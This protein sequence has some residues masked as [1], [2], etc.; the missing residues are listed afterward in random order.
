MIG[1]LVR[2][3]GFRKYTRNRVAV[4]A[5]GVVGVYALVAIWVA[6]GGVS[7]N[8]VNRRVLPNQWPGAF[9]ET[10]SFEKQVKEMRDRANEI[11]RVFGR[12]AASENPLSNLQ[13]LN[14]AERD[15]LEAPF[16]ELQLLAQRVFEARDELIQPLSRY[17]DGADLVAVAEEEI[18]KL[19]EQGVTSGPAYDRFKGGLEEG[20]ADVENFEPLVAEGL[21]KLQASIDALIPE[22][23]GWDGFIYSLRTVLGSDSQGRSISSKAVYSTKVA[24]QIGFVVAMFC[25][26]FGTLMG[27]AA[28][29]YGGWVDYFVMWLVSTL[30]SIPYIVLLAVIVFMFTGHDLFDNASKPGFALVPVYAAMGLTF[31]ISTC[32]AVRGEVMRIKELE[33]VQAATSIGF[34]K[35]YILLKHVV[36]NTVH[37]MFIN[38]SLLFIGAIKSEVILSFL[39]LGVK[40][41]PSWGVMISQ[42]KDDVSG[43]FFWEVLTA[44]VFM[45]G[46]VYAFNI[47]SDALQ[48]AFDPKHV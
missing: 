40:G 48:D 3:R 7:L 38:F 12:A 2:S 46:L 24:F 41:Q 16:E 13:T 23:E 32:R 27:S 17:Q 5:I 47:V 35:L 25:V 15:V 9:L 19:A 20:L 28:A 29:F 36:P 44:T 4:V 6:L 10:P 39:G 1:R 43:F 31:W 26:V 8:D 22:P 30:S 33:Y 42:G 37:L 14:W 11:E 21:V 45:F 34:G 18:R